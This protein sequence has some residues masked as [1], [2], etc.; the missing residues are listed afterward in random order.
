MAIARQQ[1]APDP[2]ILKPAADRLVRHPVTL[3]ELAADGEDV[4]QSPYSLYWYRRM[5]TGD[6]EV[7]SAKTKA[8][9]RA[10][11]E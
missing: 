1:A 11:E 10:R 7:V 8:P 4:S 5:A 2:L 6:V 3:A 9:A